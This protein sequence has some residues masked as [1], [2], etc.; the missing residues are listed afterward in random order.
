MPSVLTA[1]W[2]CMRPGRTA[3][4]QGL[5]QLSDQFA[6]VAPGDAGEARM[7]QGRTGPCWSSH[8]GMP[9]QHARAAQALPGQPL[10]RGLRGTGLS[11]PAP[12]PATL[13]STVQDVHAVMDAAE[14]KHA[15]LFGVAV[16]AGICTA[17]ALRHPE[18][19]R[20]LILW[21]AHARL[22]ATPGYP[23]GWS[24]E[25]FASVVEGVEMLGELHTPTLLVHRTDD[26][27][28]SVE[29]SRYVAARITDAKLVELPGGGPLAVDRRHGCGP[30]RGAGVPDGVPAQP[31]GPPGVGP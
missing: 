12:G 21:D 17:F 30:G 6:K 16:G 3:P 26:P 14:S 7:G 28:L 23:A 20:S 4:A 19:T 13:D 22:L 9:S 1:V 31:A 27:W 29:H 15:T 24:E 18:R 2:S 10:D 5:G 8:L 11:D 25:F